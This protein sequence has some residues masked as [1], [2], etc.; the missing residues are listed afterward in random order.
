MDQDRQ[1]IPEMGTPVKHVLSPV[2]R[3]LNWGSISRDPQLISAVM[4]YI[5]LSEFYYVHNYDLVPETFKLSIL[6]RI[7]VERINKSFL[8][9][10]RMGKCVC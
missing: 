8:F 7:Q 5:L 6:G 9:S 3:V 4:M 2:A 10:W 1:G